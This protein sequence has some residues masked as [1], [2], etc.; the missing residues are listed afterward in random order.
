MSLR[1]RLA[2]AM[3]VAAL[4]PMVVV[5]GVP[6]A[7]AGARAREESERRLDLARR[8][9]RFVIERT[10][11][12]TGSRV[13]SAASE[14]GSNPA[15]I[16][17]VLGGPEEAAHAVARSLAERHGLD[18]LDL[19]GADATVLATSRSDLAA[20]S[21][22]ALASIP[23]GTAVVL[24]ASPE[25]EA[26]VVSIFVRRGVPYPRESIAIVGGRPI[27]GDLVRDIAEITGEPASLL[28]GSGRVLDRSGEPSEP[29]DRVASDVPL[30]EGGF[31]I[32]VSSPAGDVRRERRDL[33]TAFAG[34]APLALVA[35]LVVGVLFADR[36]SRPIRAL[37]LRA[38][39]IRTGRVGF[40]LVDPE[41]DE[42]LRLTRSFERMVDSLAG[43]ERARL[44]AER[45]AA[46]QEVAQRI[47]HEVK[48]PLSP[49]RL[50]VENLRRT[51]EKAP[52][53]LDRALEEE[54][55]T[56]L[57]EVESLRRLVDEFSRFARLPRPHPIACDP[58]QLVEQTLSLFASRI[59]TMGA[60]VR[61][62]AEGAP[63]RIHA[64]PDQIGQVLKNVLAN[65]LDALEEASERQLHV[66]LRRDDG[67]GLGIRIE[68][69]DTGKG[70]TS[71]EARRIFEP[72]FTT[73]K[74]RGGTGLGM[75]IAY[76][77][78]TDHG[79]S[80]EA[81]GLPGRGATITIR[82]PIAG[83]KE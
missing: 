36:I 23:E 66:V 11:R 73:R 10:R 54:S 13:E 44:A 79:G 14:L 27:G 34:I 75:A 15:A 8:Q 49:I 24:P 57:E 18:P 26:G 52:E 40:A 51:R 39:E 53:D 67:L 20:G 31:R 5:V 29:G 72:Y 64:D 28:D 69:R 38:D 25:S 61:L 60:R 50:A 37:A 63:D 65:A 59:D 78:V 47:A 3:M 58:R 17:R 12:E 21:K 68:V 45:V 42:V 81:V 33:W 30:G 82:L 16:E 77:I 7:R 48:N 62:D 71:E 22:S 55:R 46:W 43:S 70:L 74:E 9:A 19:V 76:R 41:R 83:P 56:I 80:I 1:A 4:L 6:L 35:A 32:Q 2:L